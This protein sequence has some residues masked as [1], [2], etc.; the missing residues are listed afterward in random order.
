[1]S[2]SDKDSPRAGAGVHPD[3]TV[4]RDFDPGDAVPWFYS[5]DNGDS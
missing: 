2:V 3:N 5:P 4:D 1:M